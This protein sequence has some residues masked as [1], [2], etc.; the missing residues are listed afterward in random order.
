M[1]AVRTAS[2]T[3]ADTAP[4]SLTQRGARTGL[5]CQ[6]CGSDRVTAL[7]MTLTD[8]TPAQ[9]LSCHTCENR[10]W[11]AAGSVLGFDDVIKRT[12]KLR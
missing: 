6:T 1:P 8:G 5:T 12:T 4:A 7:A 10:T 11:M 9:F 2:M 3:A